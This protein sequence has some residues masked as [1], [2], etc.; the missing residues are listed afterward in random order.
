[1]RVVENKATRL[2]RDTDQRAEC[3]LTSSSKPNAPR[4]LPMPPD[5]DVGIGT[6]DGSGINFSLILLKKDMIG[7]GL[8]TPKNGERIDVYGEWKGLLHAKTCTAGL[9]GK[10]LRQCWKTVENQGISVRQPHI[11]NAALYRDRGRAAQ[12]YTNVAWKSAGGG[13]GAEKGR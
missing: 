8:R 3:L 9:M 12:H 6:L 2:R 1:L 11:I 5:A 13:G 7:D 4:L 10:G